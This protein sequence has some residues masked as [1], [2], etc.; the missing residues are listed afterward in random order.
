[1]KVREIAVP[2]IFGFV[3]YV[4]SYGMPLPADLQSLHIFA[5]AG[6]LCGLFLGKPVEAKIRSW[7][8]RYQVGITLLIIVLFVLLL[9]GYLEL[10]ANNPTGFL[11]LLSISALLA[12]S[13][14]F[15]AILLFVAG[16]SFS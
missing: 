3:A 4:M 14:L 10:T 15:L 13:F 7:S 1:M 5:V 9:S 6:T 16:I 12:A 8:T 2:G 11:G